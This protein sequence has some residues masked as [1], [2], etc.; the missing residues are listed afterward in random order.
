MTAY[1]MRFGSKGGEEVEDWLWVI[2]NRV[3]KG[4][5]WVEEWRD[6]IVVPVVKKGVG[7][8]VEDYRGIT[9]TQTAYKVYAAVLAERLRQEVEEKRLLP[10][11]QAGF[12]RGMGCMDNIYVLNHLIN[13]QVTRKERKMVV[14]FIDLKAA[15]DSVDRE[16]LVREMRKRGVREGLVERCGEVLKETV[17]RVRVGEEEGKEFWTT[18][19]V[20]QGCPL[21]PSMFTLLLADLDEELEKGGWGGVRLGGRKV[22]TL[23][24]A[25]DVAVV[26]E[27]EEGMKGMMGKLERY[28][29]RKGL[30]LNV[31]KSKIM[32]CRRGGGR[33]RRVV[34]RWKGKEVEEVKTFK[35]LGYTLMGSGGQEA[36]VEERVRK[37]AAV[38][39][40][41]WGIG[42]RRFGK[43]WGK[44]IWL[45]DKLVWA[46]MSYGVEIWG[47]R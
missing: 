14:F 30:H 42:K 17:C 3:W 22:Y 12:R 5:G 28:M 46:T 25:D 2:C 44:R 40:R 9:L 26:A 24:Y 31:G 10:P 45:F 23:A 6:G 43:D 18:R 8:K 33:W 38:M 36:H 29:D 4:E 27:D 13:R 35:Y 1:P 20:R 32:R 37:A 39:G 41:V 19:G 34:W 21:S 7:K 11:S 47:G 16:V 15:F